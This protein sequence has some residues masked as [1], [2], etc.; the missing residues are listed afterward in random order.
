MNEHS[1]RVLEYDRF[2][3]LLCRYARSEPG[4]AR[5]RA[6]RPSIQ[7][8][9]VAA[10]QQLYAQCL[11]L[12]RQG[13]SLPPAQ[14]DNPEEVLARATP[15]RSVLDP[16][17]FLALRALLGAADDVRRFALN[18][19]C[20]A[21][22]A[23]QELAGGLHPCPDL[24]GGIAE[25]FEGDKGHVRDG[26]SR[27]LRELRV[28]IA[29]LE[30]DIQSRL[31]RLL[32]DP[33]RAAAFQ[34]QFVTTRSGRH[35]LPVRR[36]LRARV[37][38][39]VHDQSNSGMT[40]FVEPESTVE[41]GN[42]LELQRLEERD[43]IRRILVVLTGVLRE[44]IPLIRRNLDLLCRYDA[45]FAVSAWA[46]ENGCAIP[47]V[48]ERMTLVQAHHPLL[49]QRLALDGRLADLVP[50]DL[51]VPPGKNVVVITGSNTGGK[52]VTLKTIG[53][54]TA[55]AQAG[56]PVPAAEGTRVRFFADILA[57]I[58]DEQSIEQSL[59][60][61]SA[62]LGNIG[63]ALAAGQANAAL[64]LLDELG[65][66]TDPLEGGALGCAIL[67]A[68]SKAPGLT[69]ATTHLGAVK[70]F[71]HTRP[72]MENASMLFD[73]ETLRPLYR[74]MMGRAG[75]SYALTVAERRGLP[76]EVVAEARQL[77]TEEDQ[78]IES[79]LSALDETQLKMDREVR[80]LRQTRGEAEQTRDRA[81]Q[82]LDRLSRE[83]RAL[84]QD[85]R[86][87][88]HEAQNEAAALIVR[89]R[90]ELE[91]ILDRARREPSRQQARELRGEVA[92][93]EQQ[94]A[95]QLQGTREQPE[96]PVAGAEVRVGARVW[97]EPL[98]DHG[99]VAGLAEGGERVT[100]EV[101][102]LRVEVKRSD[103][104][105]PRTA[106]RAAARPPVRHRA[107]PG[108]AVEAHRELNLI[109]QRVDEARA[110]LGLF[111]DTAVAA[112]LPEVRIVH[113]YG[114][115]ALRNAVHEHL[116]AVG[117]KQFRQGVTGEDPG[118]PGVTLVT[119]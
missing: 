8:A 57:D 72:A 113:G 9:D 117:L 111:L 80:D 1:L 21:A 51:E 94:I 49:Q 102:A 69:F 63:E 16:E 119:L 101:G 87:L 54:L 60:T 104:G 28:R 2:L 105:Q 92:R 52:T 29:A 27:R 14:F 17:A 55:I 22:P 5:L 31:E 81:Q 45:A 33:D 56:L 68:L 110:R 108:G 58:G 15:D 79:M 75:A 85:R 25:T 91:Q 42:E 65:A 74:L 62:H 99:R 35:V 23:M 78:R 26:A 30:R 83:L 64:V 50:L 89:T 41:P 24:T 66:G 32:K 10:D 114:T 77:M 107:A 98:K 100:V 61:F 36:E 46:A 93:Q 18:Q 20:S 76:R 73:A 48:G 44:H 19:R 43:E 70:R 3:E 40:L 71:V 86:K 38:G 11:A 116:R 12:R 7:P 118:G 4:Q 13:L 6:L 103:L 106:E 82:D 109:G 97:V 95:A 90:R 53:L 96:E 39:I 112:G 67:D 59:S 37:A 34:D 115:G 88:M 47:Q 84:R